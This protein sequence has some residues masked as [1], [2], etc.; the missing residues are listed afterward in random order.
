MY[1]VL[2]PHLISGGH[3]F[4]FYLMGVQRKKKR[5]IL[6]LQQ[7]NDK[8]QFGILGLITEKMATE[9][10]F[11]MIVFLGFQESKLSLAIKFIYD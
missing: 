10:I 11:N 7:E 6:I 3:L 1:S 4:T 9:N 5:G 2:P 8:E